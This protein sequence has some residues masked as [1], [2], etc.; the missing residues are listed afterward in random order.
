MQLL[1]RFKGHR[2]KFQPDL[3]IRNFWSKV[4]LLDYSPNER[5]YR[6]SEGVYTPMYRL[7]SIIISGYFC[8]RTSPSPCKGHFLPKIL[9][10][11]IL[12]SRGANW[13]WVELNAFWQAWEVFYGYLIF[14]KKLTLRLSEKKKK[15]FRI[16]MI[17]V[18]LTMF[19]VFF[20]KKIFLGPRPLPW[21]TWT[22]K[23]FFLR[24]R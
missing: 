5:F 19:L 15:K 9:Y 21:S 23:L 22:Q 8:V 12:S 11:S 14:S 24:N 3:G 16:N 10:S 4:S 13:V 7:L 1:I 2:N 6:D 18:V 20:R 17:G